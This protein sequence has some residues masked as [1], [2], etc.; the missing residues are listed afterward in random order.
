MNL[1]QGFGNNQSYYQPQR[2]NTILPPS[3]Q[4]QPAFIGLKGRPVSSLEEAR[5][6]AIDF[7]G[8]VFFFPDLANKRIYTKQINLDGTASMNMY[9]YKEVPTEAFNS[10][11]FVTRQEFDETLNDIKSA[12]NMIAQ[13]TQQQ[14]QQPKVEEQLKQ[15]INF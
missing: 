4:P 6:A 3:Q 5:A 1:Y 2:T 11:N 14:K 13:Q 8:S 15:Q 9:E 10:S 12:L 7:D